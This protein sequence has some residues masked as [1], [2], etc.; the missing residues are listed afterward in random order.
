[1]DSRRDRVPISSAMA[2]LERF[3]TDRRGLALIGLW[4]FAEA[5]VL[6]VVPDV[7]LGLL[8]LVAPRRT[9]VLFAWLIAASLAGTA[10]LFVA[11]T[12]A[13]DA[14]TATILAL[15]GITAPMLHDA[16][17]TVATGSPMALALFGPGTPLKVYTLAWAIGPAT[18]LPL[19][20]G[21]IVN[22]LT[23]I[24]PGLVTLAVIGRA[25]PG[26]VRRHERLVLLAYATFWIVLYSIYLS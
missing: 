15:P 13:R 1:M 20:T 24:G 10:V 11:V 2:R 4:A 19:A 22:R 17:A 7:A 25:A 26:F 16:R 8:V 21:A 14:V 6:P 23:R 9:L 12:F 18:V 5:I 3:A